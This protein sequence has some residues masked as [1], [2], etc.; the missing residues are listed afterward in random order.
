LHEF[1]HISMFQFHQLHEFI[2]F[3]MLSPFAWLH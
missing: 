2:R 1:I 3:L